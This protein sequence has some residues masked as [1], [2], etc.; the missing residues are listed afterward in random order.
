MYHIQEEQHRAGRGSNI[1][2][3]VA[4]FRIILFIVLILARVLTCNNDRE[5]YPR[6]NF[7]NNSRE[8]K[9][10]L[11]T[12]GNKITIDSFIKRLQQEKKKKINKQMTH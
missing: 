4:T 1:D 7:E 11:I 5:R 8:E 10:S 3:G 2:N 6:Y 12:D 9:S